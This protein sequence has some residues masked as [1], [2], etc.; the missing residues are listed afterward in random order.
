MYH[1]SPTTSGFYVREI[2]RGAIPA[3]A[4]EIT[5]A[6]HAALMAGQGQGKRI[7]AGPSGPVLADPPAP[8]PEQVMSFT[9]TAIQ[10]LLD[11]TAQDHG[12]DNIRSVISYNGSKVPKWKAEALRAQEWRDDC[13]LQAQTIQA[14][15]LS[16]GPLPTVEQVVAQM[17]PANW[18]V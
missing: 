10:N 8:T 2:H 18:P 4:V 11:I 16:G 17:P 12:Y 3:D 1:Y 14:T 5:D 7:V 13:W 9:I 15:F 6:Q